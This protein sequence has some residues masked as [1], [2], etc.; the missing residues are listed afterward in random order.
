MRKGTRY[1][2]LQPYLANGASRP[3]AET[4]AQLGMSEGAI[5]VAVHRLR[6]QFRQTLRDE[7]AATVD[8]EAEIDEERGFLLAAL[9]R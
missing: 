8:N 6:E 2:A 5:K 7:I 9:S 1:A 4:A 3:H